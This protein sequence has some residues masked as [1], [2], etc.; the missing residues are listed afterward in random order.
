MQEQKTE[1]S[2]EVS[3]SGAVKYEWLSGW[4][5]TLGTQDAEEAW[6]HKLALDEKVA[7]ISNPNKPHGRMYDLPSYQSPITG[8]W[9]DGRVARKNDLASSGCVE[10]DP[11]MKSEQ[12]RRFAQ[13]DAALDKKVDEHVEKTI[14]EMPTEKREKLASELENFDVGVT[15]L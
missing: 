11:G 8:K 15:R 1:A 13:E 10:Y 2:K 4:N 14:Y 3:A 5:Y 9:I 7:N 6:K 12:D